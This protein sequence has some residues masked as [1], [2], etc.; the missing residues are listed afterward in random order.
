M[1]E[2]KQWVIRNNKSTAPLISFLL[3]A[4]LV[5]IDVYY[6]GLAIY[7][8]PLAIFLTFHYT[9]LYRLK[10]R[11]F[12]G[13][14]VIVIIAVLFTAVSVHAIYNSNFSYPSE[15]SDGSG[16][17]SKVTPFSGSAPEYTY[18]FLITPNGSFNYST[19]QLNIYGQYGY[20]KTIPYS[21]MSVQNFSGNNTELIT[22][23]F[24]GI[25]AS[26][27]YSYNLTAQKNGTTI[28]TPQFPGPLNTSELYIIYLELLSNATYWIIVLELIFIAGLFIARSLG[29][30]RNIR[31]SNL[32]PPE[33]G[34]KQ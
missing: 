19:L 16:I 22:Y 7:L 15:F 10:M 4:L 24:T 13:S 9:K 17:S 34:P 11:A 30:A 26:G 14:I 3:S 21:S 2:L 8:V 28:T 1:S 18:S 31:Q 25:T 5:Y 6:M 33:E 29:N 27:A 12:G 32:K 20:S 23:V